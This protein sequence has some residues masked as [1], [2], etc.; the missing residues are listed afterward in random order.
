MIALESHDESSSGGGGTSLTISDCSEILQDAQLG[1]S[2]SVNGTTP[3][4][5]FC[6]SSE[7]PSILGI[8]GD[9]GF[10]DLLGW[11]IILNC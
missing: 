11:E 9:V 6:D 7:T 3:M 4:P 8:L 10:D 5:P 2:I 1:D